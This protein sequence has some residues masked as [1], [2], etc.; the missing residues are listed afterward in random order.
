[1]GK[2][3]QDGKDGVSIYKVGTYRNGDG[4]YS[5]DLSTVELPE[6]RT[7]QVGDFLL[8]EDGTLLQVTQIGNEEISDYWLGCAFVLNTIGAQGPQGEKGDTGVQGPQGEKGDTGAQGPQGE[9]GDTGAQG[10]QGADGVSIT[11]VTRPNDDFLRI[12]KSDGTAVSI[13]LSNG[14]DGRDGNGI[15]SI[16][17]TVTSTEDGGYNEITV[18]YTDAQ[19]ES[20]TL[21]VKN[22]SKGDP[23]DSGVY[24]GGEADKPADTKVLVDPNAQEE[25]VIPEVLQSTGDSEE[26]TMSQKAITRL[27]AQ[28]SVPDYIT[29]EAERVAGAVRSV[30]TAKTLVLVCGSDLHPK[31]GDASEN[32][33]YSL[34]SAQHAGMGMRALKKRI[35][36]DC[37]ALLGDYSYMNPDEY[38][39]EQTMKDLALAKKTLD[40]DEGKAVWSIGNHDWCYGSGTDRL[41][42]EDEIYSFIGAN[43]DGVKPFAEIERGYGYVDF[44][45]YKIRIINLN[46]CDCKDGVD[47][48]TDYQNSTNYAR[49][50]FVS[51]TQMRWLADVAL[52]FTNKGAGWGVVFVSHHPLDYGNAW[53]ADVLK[54]LEAYR[55]SS[56]VTLNLYSYH[57]GTAWVKQEETFDFT[58]TTPAKIICNIHGHS[59][60]C[61]SAKV[62]SSTCTANATS[63]VEPWL[64]RFC[65]PNMCVGRENEKWSTIHGEVDESGAAIYHT[66]ETG[67]AKATSFTVV[68]IDRKNQMIYAHAFGAG[69][70]RAFYY[71]EDVVEEPSNLLDLSV[72]AFDASYTDNYIE[73]TAAHTMDYTKVYAVSYEN[74]RGA[75]PATKFS[76]FTVLEN[77]GFSANCSSSSGYR[78]EFPVNVEGGKTYTLNVNSDATEYNLY[79]LKYNGDTTLNSSD[80]L[81]SKAVGAQS[82][83]FTAEGGYFYSIVFP[84]GSGERSYTDLSLVKST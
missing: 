31:D 47:N 72:R 35:G 82:V 27:F 13:A 60:N 18:T 63:G 21:F 6:G 83:N 53:F 80:E 49:L 12:E 79:L 32:H 66:K 50:E 64:W 30:R 34:A 28:G 15:E 58:N 33:P 46:T 84:F 44:D 71:G 57:D 42:S 5:S 69:K 61:G 55:A 65:V 17:Q 4:A 45:N 74:K 29:A 10:P 38:T 26:D 51:P 14:E 1:N 40:L 81:L 70:D 52:D 16:E 23:G 59:H 68:S 24:V 62:S 73:S 11:N 8:H 78:L 19:Y 20:T 2:D 43:S 9:K 76:E 36:I 25:I 54:M 75:H 37:V 7:L 48:G 77:N 56:S 39:A 3:G 67:T 22:G 41:L